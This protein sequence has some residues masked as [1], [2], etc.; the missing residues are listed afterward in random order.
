MNFK[1][2][3]QTVY[4]GSL[5][6]KKKVTT[7]DFLGRSNRP[8]RVLKLLSFCL[9]RYDTNTETRIKKLVNLSLLSSQKKNQRD[10]I[11]FLV[12]IINQTMI[13]MINPIKRKQIERRRR[14]NVKNWKKK[15]FSFSVLTFFFLSQRQIFIN[16]NKSQKGKI[17]AHIFRLE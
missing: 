4:N 13:T 5:K 6:K 11:V 3:N 10:K 1:E 12:C 9:A 16:L 7:L 14:T 2:K 8:S 17:C 15:R